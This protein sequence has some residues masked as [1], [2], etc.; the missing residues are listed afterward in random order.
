MYEGRRLLTKLAEGRVCLGTWVFST[1]YTMVELLCES[2]Y[3]F[4]VIDAEHCA[5]NVETVQ[6]CITAG[7]GSDVTIVVRVAWNDPVLIKQVLDAGAGG[8]IVP[9]IRS[10][11]EARQ[12][13]AACMYPP[14]GIRGFG[15]RRPSS[16]HRRAME[17]LASANENIVVLAQLE[18]IDA[19]N[20]IDQIL[21]V[22]G[23][24]GVIIGRNDL[25]GSM[26]VLGQ[27]EHPQVVAAIDQVLSAARRTGAHVGMVSSS[28][29]QQALRWVERGMHFVTLEN[30]D[31]FLV[32]ASEAAVN[33]TRALL[34]EREVAGFPMHRPGR[35]GCP[36][37][38][39]L[40][41]QAR[42]ED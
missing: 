14:D 19:V 10:A 33:G 1:D 28:D 16:Y 3:D 20:C 34:V 12:A 13:V 42:K 5:F 39:R 7:G 18:H 38:E 9:L 8:V 41:T 31:G 24:T 25:S 4:I 6:A 36:Q 11:E 30:S 32:Q 37:S 15:P 2:G 35:D 26:G 27:H 29:P 40:A 23:L 17:Y 22:P 21:A